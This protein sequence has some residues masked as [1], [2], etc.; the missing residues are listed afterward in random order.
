[1]IRPSN[2]SNARLVDS[3]VF[4]MRSYTVRLRPDRP[5]CCECKTT[6]NI[7]MVETKLNKDHTANLWYYCAD[8]IELAQRE[9]EALRTGKY[10]NYAIVSLKK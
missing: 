3:A 4:G 6:E 8:H 1:M 2:S 10:L 9:L 7:V 5:Q